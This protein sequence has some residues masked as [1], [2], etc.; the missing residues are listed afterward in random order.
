MCFATEKEEADREAAGGHGA[1]KRHSSLGKIASG[2][3]SK[4]KQIEGAK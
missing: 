2:Q 3:A 1:A 4:M